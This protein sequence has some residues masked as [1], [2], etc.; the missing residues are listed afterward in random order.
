MV[1]HPTEVRIRLACL[2]LPTHLFSNVFIEGTLVEGTLA[3]CSC[4]TLRVS[5]AAI[6]RLPTGVRLVPFGRALRQFSSLRLE[7]AVDLV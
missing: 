3:P 7:L 2:T 5:I 6:V 1:C 4:V